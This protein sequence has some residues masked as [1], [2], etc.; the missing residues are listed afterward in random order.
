M[1][2]LA[3]STNIKHTH[4]LTSIDSN[5]C[6]VRERDLLFNM[7]DQLDGIYRLNSG[8][9]KLSRNTRDGEKQIIGFYTAGDLIG[10]DALSDGYS[11]SKAVILETANI[12]LIPFEDI[13]N[14]CDTFDHHAFMHQLGVNF[15]HENDHTMMLSQPADRRIA[16]FLTKHSDKLKNRGL[17]SKEFRIPMTGTDLAVYLG[18]ALET[19]SREFGKLSKLGIINKSNKEFGL[20]DLDA[21]KKIANGNDDIGIWE[22]NN[23][24]QSVLSH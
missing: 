17:S 16:W 9:I 11:R 22:T 19:L 14:K 8:C 20:L 23:I 7:G 4:H 5:A 2:H 18:M 13:L 15:N 3:T 6:V 1:T 21:L 10:L 24:K 12:T